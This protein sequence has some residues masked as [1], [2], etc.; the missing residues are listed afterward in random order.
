MHR[1]T[2]YGWMR[3]FN[4]VPSWGARIEEAW[5]DY[6]PEAF[7]QELELLRQAHANTIRLWI[8]FTAWMAD[9]EAITGEFLDAVTAIDE[10]GMKTMPCLFNRWHDACWDYGGTYEENLRGDLEPM[11]GYVAALV[12]PLAADERILVWDLCNE[13]QAAAPEQPVAELEKVWLSAVRE[14]VLGSGAQQPITIGAH[15]GGDS[16]NLWAPLSDVLCCHP[17]SYGEEQVQANLVRCRAV[18]ERWGKPMLCNEGGI[19]G[20]DDLARAANARLELTAWEKAGWGWLGWTPHP[21]EAVASRRDRMDGNG[22]NGAGYHPWFTEEGKLRA[23]ME[24]LA[25]TPKR[26]PP[27]LG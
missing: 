17:Y 11:L 10:Q 7:R 9:P 12:T 13:P 14:T 25:E 4:L 6:D 3:G 26:R 24:W 18:Q 27:W 15:N 20:V 2:D 19:G 23:G 5:W 1:Y 16:M 22:V 21:G 8:E